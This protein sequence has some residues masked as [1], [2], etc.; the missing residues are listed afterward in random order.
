MKKIENFDTKGAM[1]IITSNESIAD[2]TDETYTK[3]IQMHPSPSRNIQIPE[4]SNDST[5]ILQVKDFEVKTS[6]LSFANGSSSGID[7]I[8]PQHLKDLISVSAGEHGIK[9]LASI[10]KLINFMLEG[11]VKDCIVKYI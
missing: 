3:L 8:S 10:T 6:I 5:P 11:K 4:P 1:R 2:M 7:G 9:L